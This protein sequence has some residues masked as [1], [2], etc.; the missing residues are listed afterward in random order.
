MHMDHLSV[1]KGKIESLRTEIA[2]IL[3]L[4]VEYRT[5]KR[6]E[7]V[8]HI[9]H[10]QR[11]ARLEQIKEELAHLAGLG[12]SIRAAGQIRESHRPDQIHLLK[13]SSPEKKAVQTLTAAPGLKRK[14][15]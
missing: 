5:A 1:L 8:E 2:R 12:R 14:Y 6:H 7:T 4:N 9:A 3:E 10:T 13:N 11:H 15:S